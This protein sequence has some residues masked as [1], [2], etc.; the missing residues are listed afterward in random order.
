MDALLLDASVTCMRDDI[1]AGNGED[2]VLCQ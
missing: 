1:T 2:M